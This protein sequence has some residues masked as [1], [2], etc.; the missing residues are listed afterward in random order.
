MTLCVAAWLGG[1]EGGCV[2]V[3]ESMLVNVCA[4]EDVCFLVMLKEA[5]FTL[6]VT[7]SLRRASVR[8]L[9]FHVPLCVTFI[10]TLSRDPSSVMCLP[11]HI[12]LPLSFFPFS[13]S[14]SLSLFFS[15]PS[16]VHATRP[17]CGFQANFEG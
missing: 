8:G 3:A 7:T 6:P 15:L 10:L 17:A 2:C 5:V 9:I 1:V 11:I 16:L 4:E 13:L 12:S 14:L